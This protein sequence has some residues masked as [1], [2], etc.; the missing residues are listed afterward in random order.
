MTNLKGD[1]VEMVE[2]KVQ[3][4]TNLKEAYKVEKNVQGMRI[5]DV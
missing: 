5:R 1:K 4:M 2:K 3:H